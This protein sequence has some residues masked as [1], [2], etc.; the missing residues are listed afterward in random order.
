MLASRI[1]YESQLA[2]I[3][4]LFFIP[5]SI[6]EDDI[7][8]GDGDDLIGGGAGSDNIR[9]GDGHDFINTSATL[10]VLQRS[11]ATDSW[12]PPADQGIITQGA[13]WGIYKDIQADGDPVIVWSGSNSPAGNDADVVDAGAGDDWVIASGGGDRV[14]GGLG[15]DQIEGMGGSDILE[16]GGGTDTISGDGLAKPLR[17]S[18]AN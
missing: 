4:L 7:F 8:G 18:D 16:G 10:S 14:Q 5:L 15:D 1:R 11:K 6:G 3:S 17:A 12:S 13:R 2:G 9:G